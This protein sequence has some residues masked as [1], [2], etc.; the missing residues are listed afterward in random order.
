MDY[1]KEKQRIEELDYRLPEKLSDILDIYK[2]AIHER[3]TSVVMIV[4]GRSGMGKTTLSNQICKYV[5]PDYDLHKIHYDP[6]TFLEGDGKKIGLVQAKKGSALLFDEAMIISS[7]SSLSAVNRM[8]VQAMS[9]IR[10]KNLFIIFCVNSL[11]DLD[12]NLALSR[13]DLVLHVYGDS[14]VNRGKFLAYFKGSDQLDR[15]KL[16]YLLGK[17][18]YDYGKPRANF[19]TRFSSNFVVDEKQYEKEK[20]IGVNEF[21]NRSSARG[22]TRKQQISRDKYIIWLKE[23]TELTTEEIGEIGDLSQRNIQKIILKNKEELNG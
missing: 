12:K 17:K 6:E 13:A 22:L 2:R 1:E 16:L 7:R 19:F 23:N 3:N 4:D 10:S 15:I 20:Q 8:I 5:D 9:M 21:L 14:L 18:Y 11:F